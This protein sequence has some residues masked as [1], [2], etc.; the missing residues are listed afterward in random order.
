MHEAPGDQVRGG[1]PTPVAVDPDAGGVVGQRGRPDDLDLRGGRREVGLEVAGCARGR[2][3]WGT[4]VGTRQIAMPAAPA[5]VEHPMP[6]TAS[7][8]RGAR[9]PV[10]FDQSRV[11]SDRW[12]PAR[13]RR[14][15]TRRWR[16]SGRVRTGSAP[17][18]PRLRVRA[19]RIGPSAAFEGGALLALGGVD[20]RPEG[21]ALLATAGGS[22]IRPRA[23]S[24]AAPARVPWTRAG[25][26]REVRAGPAEP[27]AAC[28]TS[29]ASPWAMP[30][31]PRSLRYS[32][33]KGR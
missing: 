3:P 21:G 28:I 19:Q 29:L 24:S 4:R 22:S 30:V 14:R 6:R 8:W 12:R 17:A 27:G 11:K 1:P 9:E 31:R 5:S 20:G 25:Q 18:A 15:G 23:T 10:T 2:G 33:S 13:G 26:E 7:A 16:R 32:R